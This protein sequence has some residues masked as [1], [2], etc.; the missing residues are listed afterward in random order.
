ML[1][2]SILTWFFNLSDLL[3]PVNTSLSSARVFDLCRHYPDFTTGDNRPVKRLQQRNFYRELFLFFGCSVKVVSHLKSFD[4]NAIPRKGIC[5]DRL[6]RPTK[7]SAPATFV[8][9][10]LTSIAR[11]CL[12]TSHRE[13]FHPQVVESPFDSQHWQSYQSFHFCQHLFEKNVWQSH[14]CL[15]NPVLVKFLFRLILQRRTYYV[16]TFIAY[17]FPCIYTFYHTL[18]R[19]YRT[20]SAR[21]CHDLLFI[22]QCNYTRNRVQQDLNL[23]GSLLWLVYFFPTLPFRD[24]IRTDSTHET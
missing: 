18:N 24:A 5:S 1:D 22:H 4:R 11:L 9:L 13:V 16:L 3:L 12:R 19:E 2:L 23:Y 15:D 21:Y 10:A 6:T 8:G 20:T 7:V 17:H 14:I